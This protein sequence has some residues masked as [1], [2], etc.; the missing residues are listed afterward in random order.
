MGRPRTLDL[1]GE[2]F[3]GL[4]VIDRNSDDRRY[5]NCL[6]ICG[7]IFKT[8]PQR[9][10]KGS[11]KSCGCL[12]V[13]LYKKSIT[14]H[15]ACTDG[16]NTPEYQSYRSMINRCYNKTRSSWRTYGGRGI[17]V[18]EQS[19]LQESPFGFINF[20]KD[21]GDR[22]DD[23]SL[24]RIDSNKGY[25]KDN[26]RWSTKRLQSYNRRIIKNK[27]STSSY[28]GVCFVDSRK[29][30]WISRIGNGYDGYD[31]IGDFYTEKEAAIAYNGSC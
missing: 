21:M 15:G 29:R 9:L 7:R 30:P 26:C 4:T 31:W 2:V 18:E 22:P 27:E 20:I 6:C 17:V 14:M 28:R 12:K 8:T 13:E 1:S 23:H 25:S 19:W 10:R 16:K 24:D 11:C 3:N 5:W